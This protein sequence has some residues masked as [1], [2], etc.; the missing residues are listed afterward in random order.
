MTASIGTW[1]AFTNGSDPN[2]VTRDDADA[3]SDRKLVIAALGE[4]SF[5]TLSVSASIGTVDADE[6]ITYKFDIGGAGDLAL[7]VAIWDEASIGAMDATDLIWQDSVIWSKISWSY[8]TVTDTD[9]GSVV[10]ASDQTTS[11][12]SSTITWPSTTDSN[13]V[14]I[15]L[16]VDQSANRGPMGFDT[17][18]TSR[19]QYHSGTAGTDYSAGVGD[20]AGGGSVASTMTVTNDEAANSNMMA[21]G[22]FF[23]EVGG[24]G[25]GGDSLLARSM[26][27]GLMR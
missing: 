9:Q 18:I 2:G 6:I 17:G 4:G 27:E 1:A 25:G 26:N 21:L 19:L 12:Q 7:V 3:G 14:V 23:A 10:E 13:G 16:G 5:G 22:V 20:G 11:G 8:V 15:A 24:G